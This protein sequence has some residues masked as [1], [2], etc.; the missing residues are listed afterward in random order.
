MPFNIDQFS[1]NGAEYHGQDHNERILR[2]EYAVLK[3]QACADRAADAD[4]HH[5]QCDRL[6]GAVF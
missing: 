3:G 2:A 4:E 5:N 6:H 1:Q